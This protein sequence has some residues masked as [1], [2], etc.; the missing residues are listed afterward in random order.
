LAAE[1]LEA[2]VLD[3]ELREKK[4]WIK[5]SPRINVPLKKLIMRAYQK[6]KPIFGS[7][8]FRP[9]IEYKRDWL[10][11]NSQEGQ[12]TGAYTFGAAVAEVEINR[13]TGEVKVSKVTAAQD[14]GFPINLHP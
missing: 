14:C 6:G 2:N 1:E 7:G 8:H 9:N 12:M 5:G 10:K 4:A 3:I 11:K 13:E